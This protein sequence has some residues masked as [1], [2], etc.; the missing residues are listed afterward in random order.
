MSL[1]IPYPV[2]R[3]LN[4]N[5]SFHIHHCKH[6][7][8]FDHVIPHLSPASG[9]W[10]SLTSCFTIHI[11]DQTYGRGFI[12]QN[13]KMSSYLYLQPCRITGT[14]LAICLYTWNNSVR[15][16]YIFMKQLSTYQTYLH[17]LWYVQS[18]KI[19]LLA[20]GHLVTV[21][22]HSC[23]EHAQFLWHF[24]IIHRLGK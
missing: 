5:F 2:E 21:C 9:I 11:Q 7:L 3:L 8:H 1:T 4:W 6:Q 24:G 19:F 12:L 23:S 15:T 20:S 17:E 10:H 14:A 16:K 18:N 22:W 13:T